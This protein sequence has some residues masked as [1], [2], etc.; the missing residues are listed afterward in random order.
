M[1]NADPKTFKVFKTGNEYAKDKNHAYFLGE[2]LKNS[3]P[4]SFKAIGKYTAKDK[5]KVY[6][7]N[8]I[9]EDADAETF[10]MLSD[11]IGK[12]KN[13]VYIDGKKFKNLDA[14]T[15]KIFDRKSGTTNNNIYFKDKNSVY[16]LES[17]LGSSIQYFK[18]SD[19]ATF[20][21]LNK[22]YSKDKNKVFYI[23][24]YILEIPEADPDTFVI[25]S[26]EEH[27]ENYSKDK[28]NIFFGDKKIENADIKS[29]KIIK[30]SFSKDKNN[31]YYEYKKIENISPN[32]FKIML[33]YPVN[34]FKNKDNVYIY[35]PYD[36]YLEKGMLTT[37]EEADSET[38]EVMKYPYFKDQKHIYYKN[39]K[40][41]EADVDTF[42]A[43]NE[44]FG[45]DKNSVYYKDKKLSQISTTGF[46]VVYWNKDDKIHFLKTK[47]DIFYIENNKIEKI[48]GINA[49]TFKISNFKHFYLADKNKIYYKNRIIKG[50][51]LKTFKML[52]GNF[53]R[54]KNNIFWKGKKLENINI[55]NFKI[56][57]NNDFLES[58]YIKSDN[59][60]FCK[61]KILEGVDAKDFKVHYFD[62]S[63]EYKDSIYKNC[64]IVKK[65]EKYKY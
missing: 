13:Y 9:I 34:V 65:T 36:Y 55:N 59:K 49:E 62:N 20:E 63:S 23:N 38:F 17:D 51:G 39:I 47:N 64:E 42:T 1:K 41:N 43:I 11:S 12:D 30:G 53:S 45:K 8:K 33:T 35:R 2:I 29:F 44:F 21:N 58:D 27:R 60:I 57:G 37:I 3:S 22:H 18:N 46:E 28:N 7:S 54:D 52:N 14:E 6:S 19:P 10:I 40:L 48:D 26:N 56:L 50:V 15:I 61:D 16:F 24:S 5:N 32:G 4:E 31:V 25:L